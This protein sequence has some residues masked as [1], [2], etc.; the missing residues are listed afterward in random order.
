MNWSKQFPEDIFLTELKELVLQ[1]APSSNK[2][3]VDNLGE[4]IKEK[5]QMYGCE[6]EEIIQEKSGN[7]LIATLGHSDSCLL[8]LSHFDTVKP[9]GGLK[10]EPYRN[11]GTRIYG[12]GVFDMKAGVAMIL[13]ALYQLKE[14]NKHP[15]KKIQFF[16]NSDEELGSPSSRQLIEDYAK[17]SEYALVLEPPSGEKIK[18]SRKGGGELHLRV[19][20]KSVHSGNGHAK[21]INS[22]GELSQLIVELH[23]W[24][25]YEKGTTLSAGKIMGG[26]ATNVV[27]DYAEVIFDVRFNTLDEMERVKEKVSQLTVKKGSLEYEWS[28]LTPP[29]EFHKGTE[30]LFER[31]KQEALKEGY[32]LDHT[33]AGGTSDGNFA[34]LAGI[35]VLDGL[36]AKGDGAHAVGEYIEMADL[37]KRY[38]LFMRLLLLDS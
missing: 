26:T 14:M 17:R 35:P 36:G 5:L 31:A 8:V 4:Y 2:K 33:H 24:T 37:A 18:T 15:Q 3:A 10:I 9:I 20:G 25:D 30:A 34:A 11:E 12:P 1:E 13:T 38:A 22:I 32:E 21:G 19:H 28:Y 29:L 23:S 6:V 27:P 7:Q 16:F